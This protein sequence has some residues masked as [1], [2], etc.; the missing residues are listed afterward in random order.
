MSKKHR[1]FTPPAAEETPVIPAPAPAEKNPKGY[2]ILQHLKY[3]RQILE[4]GAFSLLA[5][6]TKEAIANL[7]EQGVIE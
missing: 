1:T 3:D 6:L 2:K 5:N 7:K 4:P